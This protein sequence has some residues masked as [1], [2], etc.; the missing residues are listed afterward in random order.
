MGPSGMEMLTTWPINVVSIHALVC[1]LLVTL[2]LFPI[3]G[4]PQKKP[5]PTTTDFA[6][7][8]DAVAGLMAKTRGEQYAKVRISEYFVRVRGEDTGP[9]VIPASQ[10][11]AELPAVAPANS[12]QA[13]QP[14]QVASQAT[15]QTG[16]ND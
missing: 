12:Q 4:R 5:S 10:S 13:A 11:T 14:Q 9:W 7:H 16:Q 6:A 3:L 15:D 1:G 8:I 2:M